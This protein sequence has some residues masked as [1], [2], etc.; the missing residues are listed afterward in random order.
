MLTLFEVTPIASVTTA[1]NAYN[2]RFVIAPSA[3][4]ANATSVRLKFRRTTFD[5]TV[6]ASI[7]LQS[8][9]YD[10]YDIDPT[11]FVQLR[12]GG[13]LDIVVSAANP[14]S[15]SVDLAVDGTRPI[16]IA[17]F[18]NTTG[19]VSAAF[20]SGVPMPAGISVYGRN[21]TSDETSAPNVTSYSAN[22]SNVYCF[23]ALEGESE[24]VAVR[25]VL[26][27]PWAIKT[28]A[29]LDQPWGDSP[30]TRAAL[31]Q[32]WGD[33]AAIRSILKQ[34]WQDALAS[35]A[36]LVQPWAISVSA[37]AMLDQPWAITAEGVRALLDQPWLIADVE[38]VR[39]YLH[40]PWS[41]AA[42]DAV[43][44]YTVTVAVGGQQVRP[45]S[46]TIEG[47]LAED[48]LSCELQLESEADYL[49]CRDG[50]DILVA[51][52]S[53]AGSEQFELVVTVLR[54]NEEFGNAQYIV[55]GLS[56]SVLMGPPYSLGYSGPLEGLAS[57]IATTLVPGVD[58]QTVDWEI[59]PGL[60]TAS[61]ETRL[62][63]LKQLAAA[64]GAVV[65]ADPDGSVRVQP[66][67]RHAVNRWSAVAADVV[68]IET[69]DCFTV[70]STFDP[71]S[72]FNRYLVGDQATSGAQ[73]TLELSDV[74]PGVKEARV[75]EVP[76]TGKLTLT[77]SGGEW[78]AIVDIG[79]EERE[80]TD[81]VEFVG[82]AGRIRFPVYKVSAVTWLQADLGT[83][84]A[85][86]D[87]AVAATIAG[88]SLARITYTTRCRLWKV[89]D[90]QPEQLQVVVEQ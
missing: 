20:T 77:H 34:P 67:Y 84:T 21:V 79:V 24:P 35:R 22:T 68:L 23:L 81:T 50:M 3:L 41:I 26:D 4:A 40:Q 66:E 45:A 36:T 57:S 49:R 9:T 33:A 5:Y 55:E 86:E 18:R 59:P 6:R 74:S 53:S 69:L 72:G 44:R 85:A 78:A 89:V 10:V 56:R 80:E 71:R 11:T 7:G 87:G 19:S 47:D 25:S 17:L 32:P 39:A 28:G 16:V 12:Q 63:L 58:W 60:W 82:G 48:S 83:L 42:D 31:Y 70:G 37:R 61:G 73:V 15:D 90:A 8:P 51:I 76:W 2:H 52:V 14:Y 62:E 13:S 65:Q 27:Q 43:L 30:I 75:Y 38:P 64:V 1:Y 54:I 29:S 46:V 88:Q